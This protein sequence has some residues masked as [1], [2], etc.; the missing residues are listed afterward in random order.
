MTEYETVSTLE[1]SCNKMKGYNYK[2]NDWTRVAEE[3]KMPVSFSFGGENPDLGSLNFEKSIGE[4]RGVREYDDKMISSY[5]LKIMEDRD[6][7]LTDLIQ[8]KTLT[9]ANVQKKVIESMCSWEKK[10]KS[11]CKTQD[12]L[13]GVFLEPA[14]EEKEEAKTAEIEGE[15]ETEKKEEDAEKEKKEEKPKKEA[16]KSKKKAKKAKK[17]EL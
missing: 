10:K 8:S 14:K 2:D 12:E 7:Q 1:T 15:T 4:Q 6:E 3:G 5:C 9:T 17:S 13:N 16:K 11:P